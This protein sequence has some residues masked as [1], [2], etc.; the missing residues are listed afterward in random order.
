VAEF[1]PAHPFATGN[2]KIGAKVSAIRRWLLRRILVKSTLVT[3]AC[4][5]ASLIVAGT[6]VPMLGG[7]VDGNAWLMCI[8]CPIATAWP[9]STYTFWQGDRLKRAH[10]ALAAANAELALANQRLA[11]RA[12]RDAMTGLLNRE[13]IFTAVDQTRG[14]IGRGVL[15]IIDADHFKPINDTHGHLAGD[16]ALVEIASAVRAAVRPCDLV[17]RVG[18]EEFAAFLPGLTSKQAGAIAERVRA[19]VEAIRFRPPE[20]SALVPLTVSIGG[21][22][23]PPD[24]GIA[25]LMRAADRN[26]YA[27]KHGGRNA[28]VMREGTA[29]AA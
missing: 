27:A 5:L 11:D 21:T 7:I 13:A 26:L 24:A 3:F 29:A 8:L 10:T 9:A 20:S 1:S 18:G 25:D 19:A 12:S 15:F 28:V 16:A 2:L 14:R 22:P 17:G 23:C 6:M 4:V